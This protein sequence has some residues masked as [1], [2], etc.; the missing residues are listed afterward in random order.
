MIQSL[1]KFARAANQA[2]AVDT[3]HLACEMAL[4]FSTRSNLPRVDFN[5]VRGELQVILE[6]LEGYLTAPDHGV[7]ALGPGQSA[8]ILLALEELAVLDPDLIST[9]ILRILDH[10]RLDGPPV[11]LQSQSETDSI[12]SFLQRRLAS[13]RALRKLRDSRPRWQPQPQRRKAIH[14]RGPEDLQALNLQLPKTPD[15]ERQQQEEGQQQEQQEQAQQQQSAPVS[16]VGE[17]L[18]PSSVDHSSPGHLA[19]ALP[20]RPPT[21]PEEPEHST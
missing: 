2:D 4:G 19:S 11:G 7:G 6:D 13:A 9:N 14:V 18:A 16:P 12:A 21:V 5:A 20:S 8:S 10:V 3:F 17:H 1:T 15:R